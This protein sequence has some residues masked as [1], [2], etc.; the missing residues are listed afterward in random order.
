VE[1]SVKVTADRDG[2]S[3]GLHVGLLHQDFLYKFAAEAQVTLGETLAIVELIDPLVDIS[4]WTL[5]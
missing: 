5:N 3:N 4:F 1:L 2:G